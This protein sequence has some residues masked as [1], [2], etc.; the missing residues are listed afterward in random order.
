MMQL[1]VPGGLLITMTLNDRSILYATARMLKR[2]GISGSFDQLYSGHHLNHFN[3][4]SL[5]RLMEDGGFAVD[6]LLL[7]D[8]P[9]AAVD[10]V[11]ASPVSAFIQRCGVWGIFRI[12]KLTHRTYL[13]TLVCS[14]PK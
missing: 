7:H 6:R 3:T 14:K 12:G 4:T 11:G 5:R 9:L 8:I 1:C 2:A 10:V 13:Q